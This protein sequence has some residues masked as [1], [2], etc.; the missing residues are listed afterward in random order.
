MLRYS[1]DL[2]FAPVDLVPMRRMGTK[3]GSTSKKGISH[4]PID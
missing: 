3:L 4:F 1:G 2:S